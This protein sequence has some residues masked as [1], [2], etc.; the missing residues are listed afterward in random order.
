MFAR[1]IS[2]FKGKILGVPASF[3]RRKIKKTERRKLG[4]T[5]EKFAAMFLKKERG[6]KILCRNFTAGRDEIDIVARDGETLVFVEV[7]TRAETDTHGAVFAVDARK[8][9]ALKRAVDAYLRALKTRPRAVR[10]DVVEVYVCA[11]N[12]AM[13][14]VH[15][16]ALSLSGKR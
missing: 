1:I 4:D 2:F 15:H 5:G 11:E 16:R 10:F 13:R 6:M 7:K 12:F 14:A 9:Q 8:R 3:L